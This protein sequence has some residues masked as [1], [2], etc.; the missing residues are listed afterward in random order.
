[1]AVQGAQELT[2]PGRNGWWERDFEVEPKRL[3]DTEGEGERYEK[4]RGTP[5]PRGQASGQWREG[6]VC[7]HRVIVSQ[8]HR[9]AQC[10][11]PALLLTTWDGKA[12]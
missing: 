10:L 2:C 3:C 1:M 8:G 12:E 9:S 4:L 5:I 6:W 11:T 7:P